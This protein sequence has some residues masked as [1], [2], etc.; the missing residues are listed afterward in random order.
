[1]PT[2]MRRGGARY[3][4]YS[5]EGDEPPHVHVEYQ[6]QTAKFWLAPVNLAR[7]SSMRLGDLRSVARI[8]EANAGYFQEV[9]HE[10]FGR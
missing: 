4:F 6:G 7:T 10:Y 5:N 1:M 3:F 9:W 2:I 8:V